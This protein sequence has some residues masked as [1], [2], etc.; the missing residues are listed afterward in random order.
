[1]TCK[2]VHSND[3]KGDKTDGKDL[4]YDMQHMRR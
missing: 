2:C 3:R 4:H 1:M